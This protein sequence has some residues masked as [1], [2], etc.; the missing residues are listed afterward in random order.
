MQNQY[1]YIIL[2]LAIYYIIALILSIWYFIKPL[3]HLIKGVFTC[4]KEFKFRQNLVTLFNAFD[5]VV[6]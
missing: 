2:P 6:A 1:F 4:F 3:V 5:I